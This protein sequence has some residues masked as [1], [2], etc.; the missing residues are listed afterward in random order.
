M[1]KL[2][3]LILLSAIMNGILMESRLRSSREC[4]QFFNR[5]DSSVTFIVTIVIHKYHN[6][7]GTLGVLE[8]QSLGC[9]PK[10]HH[11][12]KEHIKSSSSLTRTLS[13]KTSFGYLLGLRERVFFIKKLFIKTSS[14]GSP[15]D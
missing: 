1:M 7:I 15:K 9:W 3:K 14:L 11:Q 8:A 10:R 5:I 6:L 4:F 13:L 12:V 2:E